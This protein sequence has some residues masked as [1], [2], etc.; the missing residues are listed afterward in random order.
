MAALSSGGAEL[1]PAGVRA[2]QG[3]A[4]AFYARQ[5]TK[6][7]VRA[8]VAAMIANMVHECALRRL[9]VR[10]VA[11]SPATPPMAGLPRIAR[12]PG[13]HMGL[14]LASALASY[15]NLWLLWRSL[16]REGIFVRQ[17]GWGTASAA[18]GC[19]LRR[20]WSPCWSP[21]CRC[22]RTGAHG[23]PRRA[24]WR[25]VLHDRRR[26]RGLCRAPVRLRLPAARSAGNVDH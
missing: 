16:R 26:R 19:C 20:A 4:P 9:L 17:P 25:L 11:S 1:R 7:P 3:V 6:T 22:G 13:L 24:C 12:V 18:A 8:G 10:A 14:A 15:L 21:A 2:G 5:D 23:R